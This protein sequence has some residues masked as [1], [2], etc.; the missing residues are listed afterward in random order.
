MGRGGSGRGPR[1]NRHAQGCE[2]SVTMFVD[3]PRPVRWRRLIKTPGIRR[4]ECGWRRG[5]EH[6]IVG[7]GNDGRQ[8]LPSKSRKQA[9][10]G[11]VCDG[12]GAGS[13]KVEDRSLRDYLATSSATEEEPSCK[14]CVALI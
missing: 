14:P 9:A 5:Q 3:S 2:R 12:R 1:A 13:A 11:A 4:G 6:V 7:M 8:T 10:H